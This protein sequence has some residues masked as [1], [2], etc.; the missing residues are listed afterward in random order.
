M[1]DEYIFS[2]VFNTRFYINSINLIAIEVTK[3]YKFLYLRYRSSIVI[4]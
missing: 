2:D 1:E 4:F 3:L